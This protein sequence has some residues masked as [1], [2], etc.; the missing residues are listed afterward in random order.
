MRATISAAL[1]MA[2]MLLA[3]GAAAQTKTAWLG[4]SLEYVEPGDAKNLGIPGGLKVTKV[5]EVSPAKDAGL[6]TGDIILSAGQS[7][8]T[9]IETMRNV[10]D[11]LR[12]GE[13]L[14]L[15]VRRINGK[16]EPLV[17]TLGAA[18]E[19]DDQFANDPK[20]KE[21]REKLRGQDADRRKTAEELERRLAELRQG[22]TE[23][24]AEPKPEEPPKPDVKEPERAALP[25]VIGATFRNLEPEESKK[26]GIEGGI[27]A[28]A[29]TA[30]GAADE[31][32]LK[33]DDIIS[34]AAGEA[35]TGTGHLRTL[36]SKANPGD[37]LELE[38]LRD[39][40]KITISVM[41]R[42]RQ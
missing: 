37:K 35:L 39:G 19:K 4:A 11:K 7:T 6:E 24:P 27:C 30:Q 29:V 38:V 12:P 1:V 17:V 20:V 40:K 2:I 25:V 18:P 5:Q 41:L 32:G 3:Q 9:T 26:H 34:K 13:L 23:K 15:G 21:L 16:N 14:S 33:K 42:P 36:L 10:L 8:I 31:A 28:T 22:K